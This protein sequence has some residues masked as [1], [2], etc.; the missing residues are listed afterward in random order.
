M[1]K[2]ERTNGRFFFSLMIV[3]VFL[4]TFD[5][6][7]R[8]QQIQ[9]ATP[10]SKV[11]PNSKVFVSKPVGV[12]SSSEFKV[13][14]SGDLSYLKKWVGKYTF[15]SSTKKEK[16]FFALPEI[17]TPLLNQLEAEKYSKLLK[18]FARP[19][20]AEKYDN[21]LILEGVSDQ[22]DR[23]LTHALLTVDLGTGN[24]SV[25]FVT[26]NGD[27]SKFESYGNFDELPAAAQKKIKDYIYPKTN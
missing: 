18:G 22:S 16:S 25:A 10:E 1:N 21:Y 27:E 20:P 6:G 3:S 5:V 14:K 2:D 11:P 23:S 4:L 13:A 9:P 15:P 17:K 7:C 24:L 26:Q 19:L 8:A 12:Q